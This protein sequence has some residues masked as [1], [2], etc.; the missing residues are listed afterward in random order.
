M[1]PTHCEVTVEGTIIVLGVVSILWLFGR[2]YL[3]L[4]VL[5]FFA[6]FWFYTANQTPLIN[7]FGKNA[8]GWYAAFSAV[9][10]GV[11][12]TIRNLFPDRH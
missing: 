10:F 6:M 3:G 2:L 12:V 1:W 9:L 7:L 8:L 5:Y 4:S 11:L